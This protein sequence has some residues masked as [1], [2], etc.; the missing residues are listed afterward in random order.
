MTSGL[1]WWPLVAKLCGLHCRIVPGMP[2][3]HFD[4]P[5]DILCF[6]CTERQ[7]KQR[8]AEDAKH[9]AKQAAVAQRQGF[10]VAHRRSSADLHPRSSK[11]HAVYVVGSVGRS[12]AVAGRDSSI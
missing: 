8:A 9:A 11:Q 6:V 3:G 12:A 7:E 2:S 1:L 5:S 4:L 10:S